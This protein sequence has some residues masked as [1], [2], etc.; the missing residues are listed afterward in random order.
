L[1][2]DVTEA[3]RLHKKS[4]IGGR[5]MK[6]RLLIVALALVVIGSLLSGTMALYSKSGSVTENINMKKFEFGGT[7][8]Q[9]IVWNL[10]VAP[11]ESMRLPLTFANFNGD[12]VSET[13]LGIKVGFA[14]TGGTLPADM[15]LWLVDENDPGFINHIH[16]TGYFTRLILPTGNDKKVNQPS[17]AVY[18]TWNDAGADQP[19]SVD[20]SLAGTSCQVKLT[21][22][23]NNINP[24]INP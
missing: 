8:S 5:H 15:E 1:Y 14:V 9:D 19:D 22:T 20:T 23:A 12:N 7:G 4:F 3:N 6:K 11:G 17:W 16:D 18:A 13:D 10:K 24:Q 21:F 2:Y